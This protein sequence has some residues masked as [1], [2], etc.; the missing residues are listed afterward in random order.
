VPSGRRAAA[1]LARRRGAA[2]PAARGRD[3]TA[4]AAGGGPCAEGLGDGDSGAG[5]SRWI[6]AASPRARS[7]SSSHGA[8][9]GRRHPSFSKLHAEEHIENVGPDSFKLK[10][11]LGKG[12]FGEVYQVIHK[13]TGQVYAMKVLKKSKI[14]SRNLVRYA[15]TERNLLSYIRHPFI[16]RLHYAFQTPSCLVLVLHFCSNGSLSQ[17]IHREGC[18]SEALSRLYIAEVFLAIEHLH[19]RSV[20]Y[21]DLKPENVVLDDDSHAM[22]TDF[23]LSKEG[24]EGMRG[25]GSFC[26]S[27]AYLAPEILLRAGHG[28]LVDMYGLGVLLY[29]C[30]AAHPPFYS[31]DRDTLFRN[32]A[33]AKLHA[34]TRASPVAAQFI[35]AL[36]QRDPAQR[37]G[38]RRTSDVRSHGFFNGLDWAGVLRREVPVPPLRRSSR[39]SLDA[40]SDAGGSWGAGKVASPFEGRLEAQVRRQ[41]ST[42]SQ[43]VAGWE[44][45]SPFPAGSVVSSVFCSP[46]PERQL[47]TL[48]SVVSAGPSLASG[49]RSG[50]WNCARELFRRKRR[51][52]SRG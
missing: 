19:E 15:L 18:L 37:L 5:A 16:V 4:D 28:R 11:V 41:L 46:S 21:R 40:L 12:S 13:K 47:E 33:H 50:R 6:G 36:M 20:V 34:P 24:V 52:K 2:S 26:G 1:Q 25:T 48:P 42:S 29:E 31:R 44:F 10:C 23:G 17:L 3:Q 27:V 49:R 32:I 9:T 7:R 38:A 45:A 8:R 22:L 39:L 35:H 43:E 14:I 30:M 51:A